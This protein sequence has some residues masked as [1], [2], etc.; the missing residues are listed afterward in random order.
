[1]ADVDGDAGHGE[2]PRDA[3][4]R[5]PPDD[6]PGPDGYPVVG[7]ALAFFRRPFEYRTWVAATS[8]RR[9]SSTSRNL[10]EASPGS[11]TQFRV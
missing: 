6:P 1:M 7:N 3:E 4:E 5:L 9:T 8:S 2:E 10:T 11:P